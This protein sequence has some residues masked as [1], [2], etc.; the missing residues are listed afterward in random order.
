MTRWCFQALAAVG[1]QAVRHARTC[2]PLDEQSPDLRARPRMF[3]ASRQR[4]AWAALSLASISVFAFV[5]F[6][7]TWRRRVVPAW[8]AGLYLL[9]SPAGRPWRPLPGGW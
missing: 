4:W 1:R 7:V 2:R 9:G 6:V 5:P 3:R 8:V